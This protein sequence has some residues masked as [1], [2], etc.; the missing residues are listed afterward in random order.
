MNRF[1]GKVAL[2]TGAAQGIG[3]ATAKRLIAE[4]ARVIGADLNPDTVR[5]LAA[6]GARG[7]VADVSVEESV[8]TLVDAAVGA[9][10][11]IDVLVNNAGVTSPADFLEYP[12]AEFER[13]MRIN[14]LG[15]LM[16]S[17]L[18][19]R[20][21]V[22]RQAPGAIV[23]VSS[24][25]GE[26]AIPKQTAYVISKGALNQLTKVMAVSLAE[27][28]IRVNAV[29][30]GTIATEMSRSRILAT[31]DSRRRMLLRTPLGRAGEVDEVASVIA[32]LAS[33]DASYV[34]GE[35]VN[36]DGGRLA[37]N[38]VVESVSP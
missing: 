19:A 7:V 17:Q 10:G 20:H 13:V 27:Y 31:E 35:I 21:L 5:I 23:N 2:V 12:I 4:G 1:Q 34:T 28:G 9:E 36:I 22:A 8:R 16:L 26:V 33:D 24:I 18:V 30:P 29:G 37:L 15:A 32:F 14:V 11:G 6:A 25:N 3:L 38:G